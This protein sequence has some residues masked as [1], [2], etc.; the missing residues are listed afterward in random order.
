MR[1][2]WIAVDQSL[3]HPKER[4]LTSLVFYT[5]QRIKPALQC[6]VIYDIF[7]S[8]ASKHATCDEAEGQFN[9]FGHIVRPR[10]T[11]RMRTFD[12]DLGKKQRGA[13]TQQ[14][15]G[16][17]EATLL[18]RH[19]PALV[20]GGNNAFGSPSLGCVIPVFLAGKEQPFVFS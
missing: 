20:P 5:G 1:G 12:S 10:D 19:I 17:C 8:T 7:V 14:L 6:H 15:F 11:S 18:F 2:R 16:R 9:G 13:L 4:T 3:S